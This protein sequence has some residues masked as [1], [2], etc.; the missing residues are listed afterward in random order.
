[1]KPA[2]IIVVFDMRGCNLIEAEQAARVMFQRAKDAGLP[3]DTLEL[4]YADEV[5]E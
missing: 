3:I 2:C 4:C 5:P 1:M